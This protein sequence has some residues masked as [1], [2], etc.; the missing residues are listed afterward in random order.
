VP[1]K[2]LHAPEAMLD[3]ARDLLLEEG[4]HGATIEAIS[5][6]SGAPTGSIYHRFGSRDELVTRLWMRAVR[7][8]QAAFLD[9]VDVEDP[10]MAAVSG[11]MSVF[12][13]CRSQPRDARLLVSFR[14][15]DLV[16]AAPQGPLADELRELNRPVEAA[17]A[18]LARALHGRATPAAMGHVLLVVFD[19]PYGAVRRHLIAGVDPPQRL[20]ADLERALR[21]ALAIVE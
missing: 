8:S 21:G 19:L 12:D 11:G 2:P 18:R 14:Y 1:R 6:V 9:A 5:A 4:A 17:V 20:R 16:R 7:R 13:F 3:V 15:E 10:A